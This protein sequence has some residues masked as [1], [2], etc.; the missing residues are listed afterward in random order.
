MH[1]LVTASAHFAISADGALWTE[2]ASLG[3]DFWARYLDVFDEV[4]LLVR[5][6]TCATAPEGWNRASGPGITPVALP[7][8]VGPRGLA[9]HYRTVKRI[10][11]ETL[12]DAEA[13]ALRVPC[14]I[15]QQVWRSLPP[16]RPYGAEVIGDPYDV[17]APGA[18]R[19][20]LRPFFRWWFP[21]ELRRLCAGAC[22]AG[23]VT[24]R[25]LQRR[26][27][28]PNLSV[29][30]ANVI[31]PDAA[32]VAAPR[33]LRREARPITLI[34]VGT[35]AE[36]YKAP[37][38]LIDAAGACVRD[39]LDLKLVLVGDGKYRPALTARAAALGLAGRVSFLGQLTTAE[40]IRAQLDAADLFVLPS[41]QEGL[42]RA[43]VEAMARALPCIGSTVGGI[44]ELLPPD[45]LA[46]PGEVAPLAAKIGAVVA[47]PERMAAMSA[48]NLA[49][50]REYHTDILRARRI[51][52]YEEMRGR[53]A[54][55]LR[56]RRP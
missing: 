21:R 13:V 41:R 55:W 23:Y 56:A 4:R 31:L 44:P 2:S 1:V 8:F 42:P 32:L 29:G 40:A 3:Y 14:M 30:V 51:A 53:T 35:L 38:V 36:L 22:A 46:P 49:K 7:D 20:P 26:Y 15:G 6:R 18:V 33:P 47:D 5:A 11:G 48:R 54:A 10:I 39:G 37:D 25:V 12:P 16:P 50:A 24:E 19:H 27:P 34:T 43:M 17:Y 9:R 28:C 45:D 52:L